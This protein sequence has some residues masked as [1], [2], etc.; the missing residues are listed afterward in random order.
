MKGLR[1]QQKILWF[2][3]MVLVITLKT[4]SNNENGLGI[5]KSKITALLK[6]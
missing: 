4:L 5:G 6:F 1:W 3:L 2:A